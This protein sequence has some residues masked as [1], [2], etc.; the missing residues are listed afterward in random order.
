MFSM[1]MVSNFRH[2]FLRGLY[3]SSEVSTKNSEVHVRVI[4]D[5]CTLFL[6]QLSIGFQ[7]KKKKKKKKRKERE[8]ENMYLSVEIRCYISRLITNPK[9]GIPNRTHRTH[10]ESSKM[11]IDTC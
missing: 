10:T 4:Q 1:T 2:Q 6:R 7:K 11:E 5:K 9:S 8:S 3:E